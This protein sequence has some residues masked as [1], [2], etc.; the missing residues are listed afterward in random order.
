MYGHDLK[1]HACGR[2]I[3]D[4]ITYYIFQGFYYCKEH[5]PKEL[6]YNKR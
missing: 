3:R 1:C 6:K 2:L 5:K 4:H